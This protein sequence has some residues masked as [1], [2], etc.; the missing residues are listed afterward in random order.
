MGEPNEEGPAKHAVQQTYFLYTFEPGGNRV[1]VITD[2]RLILAPDW[3]PITWTLEERR[4][5]QA[6]RTHMPESWFEYVTPP[7]PDRPTP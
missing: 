3:K 6:W 1:E 4:R 5:G 2:G 7:T